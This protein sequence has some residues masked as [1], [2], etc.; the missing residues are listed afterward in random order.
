MPAVYFTGWEARLDLAALA[1]ASREPAVLV[2]MLQRRRPA[3]HPDADLRAL[4]LATLRG[5]LVERAPLGQVRMPVLE[6]RVI[7]SLEAD[8]CYVEKLASRRC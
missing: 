7:Q 3:A 4:T 8:G 5:M 2:G 1:A 6:R